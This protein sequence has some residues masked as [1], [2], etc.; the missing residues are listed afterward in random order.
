M[1]ILDA[2]HRYKLDNLKSKGEQIL[3]FYKDPEINGEGRAGCS[4][5]EVLRVLIDRV[6]FL[7][8]QKPCR[9]NE[10]IIKHLR[11]AILLF[12]TRALRNKIEHGDEGV[13]NYALSPDGHW[14][15]KI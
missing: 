6:Y 12:E 1:K 11:L 2:G 14:S 5:Q 13:E 4:C 10:E 9:E 8:S 3:D 7:D 15:H